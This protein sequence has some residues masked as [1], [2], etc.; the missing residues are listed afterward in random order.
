MLARSGPS[1]ACAALALAALLVAPR[2]LASPED[3]FGFGARSSA[4]GRA[5]AAI[6]E[7]YEAVYSNP[8]LLSL[9][10]ERTLTI[11]LTGALFDLHANGL[12]PQEPLHG[13]VIGATVP[14]PFEGILKDR[15]ALGVGFFTPFDLVVRGRILYDETPRF[16]LPD[17]TQSVAVQAGIGIDVGYG[18]RIGGGF[19]ALAA[20]TGSVDVG[21]DASGHIGTVVEDTLVAS[22]GPIFGASVD[23]GK[24]YRV[25]ATFRGELVGRFNVV[26]NVSDLGTITVPPL[27][28]AGVPQYDPWQIALEVARVRGP[29]RAAIGATYKHWSA[30]P[31]Q[32]E[33]TVQCPTTDP[34]TGMPFTG[35]CNQAPL[36]SP[37]YHDTVT[38]YVGGERVVEAR[39]GATMALR[40]GAFFEPTPAPEQ[41]GTSNLFDNSRVG[42]SVGYGLRLAAPLPPIQLDWFTQAQIALPRTH[43]KDATVAPGSPGYPSVST[44]GAIGAMGVTLGVRF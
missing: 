37:N 27:N 13:A 35:D 40:A 25:G 4:M 20:L 41:T 33:A 10:R 11:G 18:V 36:P 34:T 42:L 28:I 1:T 15:I 21:T 5:G 39:R 12:M 29:W 24:N 32:L 38:P 8:A 3:V 43:T 17:R 44:G 2:V 6:G 22:Y 7:G 26:I 19:A 31:G 23:V 30:Y 14:L 16:L 9:E